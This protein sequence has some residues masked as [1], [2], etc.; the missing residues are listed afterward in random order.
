MTEL[1]H[2][3]VEQAFFGW[4]TEER[5]L[6]LLWNSFPDPDMA[7][8]WLRRLEP[9]VR[10]IGVGD[11]SPPAVAWSYL[12]FGDSSVLLRRVAVGDSSG[13]NN[14]HALVGA[15]DLSAAFELLRW[16]GW[17]DSVPHATVRPEPASKGD[18]AD[19]LRGQAERIEQATATVLAKLIEYPERPLSVIGCPRGY[20]I[21]MVWCL[22]AA[23]DRYLREK[24]VAR[25]WSFTTYAERHDVTVRGGLPQLVFLPVRQTGAA[26][27]D[28]EVVVLD[29]E[30][31]T[32]VDGDAGRLVAHALRGAGSSET[33]VAA[34]SSAS[35]EPLQ[36]AVR[37]DADTR[38]KQHETAHPPTERTQ[39]SGRHMRS[40]TKS[41]ASPRSLA[42]NLVRA[43]KVADFDLYLTMVVEEGRRSQARG[44]LRHALDLAA[45]DRVASRV[46][47]RADLDLHKV[48]T[49]AYG[50]RYEDL[51]EPGVLR[52]AVKIIEHSRFERLAKAMGRAVAEVSKEQAEAAGYRRWLATSSIRQVRPLRPRTW[53]V[54]AVVMIALLT[55][56]FLLG[57]AV[58][59]PDAANAGDAGPGVTSL[60]GGPTPGPVVGQAELALVSERTHRVFAFAKAGDSYFPRQPC[61]SVDSRWHCMGSAA[62]AAEDTATLVAIPVPV[63]Q[64][65]DLL[66]KAAKNEAAP[67]APDWG[68]E[69]PVV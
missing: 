42:E 8:M 21:A 29:S 26:V 36:D 17:S 69:A 62:P 4:S 31:P 41:P 13:R 68:G 46:E 54:V 6:T 40:D 52:D 56:V 65:A 34:R 59:E 55:A 38:Q 45:M 61:V 2:G 7:S 9:H 14:A 44:E 28:R 1:A 63:N 16:K 24:G 22:R 18:M 30:S 49:A 60:P 58:D 35:T 66:R 15:L 39:A 20:E 27:V 11:V 37:T 19:V 33:P 57:T 32:D 64:V 23:G 48:I 67:R 53:A 3:D 51:A 50:A 5:A 43:K 10:L 47:Q 25:S 12:E